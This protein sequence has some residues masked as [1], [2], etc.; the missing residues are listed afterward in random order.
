L[1]PKR[2]KGKLKP[3][4]N[5][6]I[7]ATPSDDA[8]DDAIIRCICG[9]KEDDGGRTMICCDECDAWQHNDCMGITEDETKVPASYLCEQCDPDGHE[10]TLAAMT[11]GEQPWLERHRLQELERRARQR[12]GGKKGKGGRQ[13]RAN[14]LKVE[15]SNEA[16]MQAEDKTMAE[17][18]KSSELAKRK[19][20]VEVDTNGKG[21]VQQRTIILPS[22]LAN[23]G[24]L[25]SPKLR[26]SSSHPQQD[27]QVQPKKRKSNASKVT[28]T[29]TTNG[30]AENISELPDNARRSA[31]QTLQARFADQIRTA[32][33]KGLYRIPDGHTADSLGDQYGLLVEY[34][35]FSNHWG[36]QLEASESYR[37]QFRAILYNIKKNESLVHRLLDNSLTTDE[38]SM[39]TSDE[40]ASEELQKKNASLKKEAEKQSTIVPETAPRFR[41]THK[42]DEPIDDQTQHIASEAITSAAPL[43][44]RRESA[45]DEADQIG[46]SP[47]D[48]HFHGFV[49]PP[50]PALA[51][52][53]LVVDTS[54][55]LPVV[56]LDRRASSNFDIQ[57]VWSSVQSPEN[58]Q[59][60][61]VQHPPRQD[62]PDI[63]QRSRLVKNDHDAE[64]DRLLDDEGNESPPYSP[65]E[66]TADQ[67]VVW[68]GRLHMPSGNRAIGSF[69]AIARHVAGSDLAMKTTLPSIFPT[70][71]LVSGRIEA[72]KADQYL[73]GLSSARY[74]D[75]CV[76]N[77]T[78]AVAND[79]EAQMEFDNLYTY[80]SGR[81][82]YGV[83]G[84]GPHREN[85][86]DNYI[87]PLD[88][89]ISEMPQFLQRLDRNDIEQPRPRR[90]LLVVFVLKWS[91]APSSNQASPSYS[92]IP[93]QGSA[94]P[95]VMTHATPAMSPGSGSYTEHSPFQQPQ[96][97]QGIPSN[98]GSPFP[99][100]P[101]AP[102][103]LQP[104]APMPINNM[105]S[106]RQILGHLLD[107]PVARQIFS[108]NPNPSLEILHNLK[109]ILETRP[110]SQND[111]EELQ[112]ALSEQNVPG[113]G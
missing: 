81:K 97:H 86:K 26:A 91:S 101:Y 3:T 75:V 61:S 5:A 16:G 53:P 1:E 34:A 28:Y 23:D 14:D 99:H 78:P 27:Q 2:P 48:S 113:G 17:P 67:G 33:K 88:E 11:R 104:A 65:T 18:L 63:P 52:N 107:C 12:K 41:R 58:D 103:P 62:G 68:K 38:F 108:S 87:V 22:K 4:S 15:A 74:T 73:C 56:S 72:E 7:E 85:V 29:T 93:N 36:I 43:S 102:A 42:G 25:Q 71:L 77:L 89:G 98:Y 13:S 35:L 44:R 92:G 40:M 109:H 10:E 112:R 45:V 30:P 59:S 105:D 84:E 60:H 57:N 37:T 55:S 31:A 24:I 94:A 100:N 111:F 46:Q 82:R 79:E 39:M 110:E 90:M 9:I 54:Q 50:L 96:Q 106:A 83:V 49:A 69:E 20:E 32:S 95:P 66:Y 6:P 80:F 47:G 76:L 51:P 64:I 21:P 70:E 8:D 19:F